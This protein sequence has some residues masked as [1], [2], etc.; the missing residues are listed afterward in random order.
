MKKKQTK[1][2]FPK[3]LA[4]QPEELEVLSPRKKLTVSQWALERRVLSP[5]TS[6]F[7]GPW[8]H[9]I[10]PWTVPIMDALSDIG[11]T[12][13]T[14]MKSVQSGG[15]EISL[16]FLGWIVDES[17][18]PTLIVM[19]REDDANRRVNTRIK[20]MFESTSTLLTHLPGQKID[21]I[22]IGKETVLDNLIL[23][24]GWAGSAAALG[25]NPVC[26]AVVDEAGK[27]QLKTGK[28]ADPVSL[29][30]DRLTTF[31]GRSKLFC[32]STPVKENDLIDREFKAGDM[33]EFWVKCS[34]CGEHHISKWAHVQ[35]DKRKDG[36]LLTDKQYERGGHARYV[37]PLC[38]KEW[39]EKNRWDAVTNG[40]FA[41]D[42][43]TVDKNGAIIGKVPI[44]THKSFRQTAFMLYPGFMTI[45]RL[46]AKW[47]YAQV[48]KRLGDIGPLQDF[49]NA[50]L[51]ES[52]EEREK[53]THE[54]VLITHIGNYPPEIIPEGV[55]MITAGFDVQL[56]H[57]YV[58]VLG[59]GHSSEVWSIY[60]AR[61]ETGDTSLLES[62]KLVEDLL[63]MQ[64]PFT[65]NKAHTMGIFKAAIDCNYRPD[66]VKDVC[67]KHND[68][69]I[70]VRG[71]GSVK[72]RI[73]RATRES[74]IVDKARDIIINLIRY[75]LNVNVLKDRLYR[76]LHESVIPGPGYMHLHSQTSEEIIRQLASEEQRKIRTGRHFK[77]VWVKKDGYRANHYWDCDVYAT[78][79]AELA[80]VRFLKP[81][82]TQ[83]AKP[84]TQQIKK[85]GSKKMTTKY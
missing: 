71:D 29:T 21:N 65:K 6:N 44:T 70:P 48:Q 39:T 16:N 24:I 69:L 79:A 36:K 49:I 57:V 85:H 38:K 55:Q 58:R 31:F 73:F 17:P 30:K 53:E 33:H 52:F 81:A 7:S 75:D 76:L 13:V 32:L 77:N 67:V 82:V 18:G 28:E 1:S 74:V 5:K 72:N 42:G 23:Y 51:T 41:P 78:A 56:D 59:W 34:F 63:E 14:L 22:N 84:Q 46:A 43:C 19:P 35:L 68:V 12:Q 11:V 45:D 37:C 26:Y 83:K 2:K 50:Y 62:Y 20:P 54:S 60:E 3:P 47:A 10:N 80:G 64:W 4:M 66:V 9:D 15:T 40:K 8:S 25:D 27:M 61:L